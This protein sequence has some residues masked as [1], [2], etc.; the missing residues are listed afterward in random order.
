MKLIENN[1]EKIQLKKSKI[2]NNKKS[3]EEIISEDLTNFQII[4]YEIIMNKKR[5]NLVSFLINILSFYLYYLSLEG[6]VGTQIDCLKIMTLDKFIDIFNLVLFSSLLSSF[7]LIFSFF[8]L[9]SIFCMIYPLIVFIIFYTLDHGSD[10]AHH[11]LY[12]FIVFCILLVLFFILLLITIYLIILYNKK[13][14]KIFYF[15]IFSSIL[16]FSLLISYLYSK[17][18]CSKWNTGLNDIALDNDRSKYTCEFVTAKNCFIN[19]FDGIFDLSKLIKKNCRKENWGFDKKEKFLKYIDNKFINITKIGFPITT[20]KDF[21]LRTQKNIEHFSERVLSRVVDMDNIPKNISK[22]EVYIDFSDKDSNKW[23]IKIDLIPNK[24]LIEERNTLSKNVNSYF[25]NILFIYIDSISRQHFK[26]KMPYLSKFIKKYLSSKNDSIAY[27]FLKYHTFA[28]FTQKNVQP[29]FYGEKMDPKSS[30]GTSIIKYFKQ[31]GYITGQ[32]SNLCSKELFVTMNNCLNNVE[33]SDYDHENVAMFC[34]PNYYDRKNPYPAF[35]GPFSVL[36]RCL[37]KKDS[38]EYILE[39]GKQFW[40][41]YSDSKKFLRLSFID[42]HESTGEVV[43]YLDKPIFDFL[44]FLLNENMMKNTVVIFAS[45][46]GNGMPSIYNLIN[47]DDYL[48]ENVLGFLSFVFFNFNLDDNIRN[49]LEIN[50]QT[51]VTPYDIHDTLIDIIFGEE[52]S[53]FKSRFGES[54]FRYI[55][56][57]ERNCETYEELTKNSFCRCLKF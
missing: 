31:R 45:D 38:Y 26:R 23:E 54:L 3:K 10:L 51:L 28:A 11:G 25:D 21:W 49:N 29:M 19:A 52:N 47:S 6:C 8:N 48:Y 33:F 37:Y 7:T 1:E 20:T 5:M 14:R 50:Q 55:N 39:Y 34:D 57:K 43:K 40:M 53:E 44:N 9:I 2:V 16:L 27:Q 41:K 18:S 46:H 4:Y 15:I 36:R 13:R 12:N 56:G 22:P 42:A 35:S 24:T 32:S 30:N 17:I